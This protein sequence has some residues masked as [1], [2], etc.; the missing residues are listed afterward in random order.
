MEARIIKKYP[1]RRLYDTARSRYI[2]VDDVRELVLEG[3]EF[4]VIDAQTEE[5]IT[6]GILI[7]IISERESGK[8]ATFTTEM[9]A[10]F[11]RLSHNA[12]QD[13]FSHYLDQSLRLFLEQQQLIHGQMEDALSAKTLSAVMQQNFKLWRNMQRSF[14]EAAGLRPPDK[15][16]AERSGKRSK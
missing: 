3:V 6:R 5:D 13:V 16:T 4:K 2:T 12:A 15:K 14:L 7:Q 1:N 9:L 11:I 10:R 8:R